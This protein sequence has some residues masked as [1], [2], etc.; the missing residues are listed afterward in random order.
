MLLKLLFQLM[1]VHSFVPHCSGKGFIT[2]LIK[3]KSSNLNS[4]EN[5]RA[6]TLGPVIAKAFENIVAVIM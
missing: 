4:V 6:I 1:V 5:Y 3:D 2:P